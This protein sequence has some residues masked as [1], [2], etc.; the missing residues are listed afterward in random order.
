[1]LGEFKK[2]HRD[3]SVK[4]L[5]MDLNFIQKPLAIGMNANHLKTKHWIISKANNLKG[6]SAFPCR[7]SRTAYK[8]SWL[9]IFGLPVLVA[10]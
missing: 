2:K 9:L 6:W 3:I 10:S 7:F 1:M 8:V 4:T 5:Y